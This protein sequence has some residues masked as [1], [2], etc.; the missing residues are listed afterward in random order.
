MK[1]KIFLKRLFEK[2]TTCIFVALVLV[3][4]LAGLLA[5][6]LAPYNPLEQVLD[7][8]LQMASSAHLMGTDHLGRDMFS[9]VLYAI[10]TTLGFAALCTCLAAMIGISLGILAGYI[11]GVLD[12]V[13]MRFCD[14]LYAFPGL[15]LVMAIVGFI[16]VGIFNVVIGMLLTQWLWYARVSR[17]LTVAEKTRSYIS[18]AKV[19]G[20]SGLKIM[21]GHI[22]PNI[23]P[24]ML[25]IFTVDFG[26]TI[27]SISGYSFLGLGVQPPGAELGAMINEGRNYINSDP[28]LIFWPGIVVLIVVVSVN[29][30][31]D[32]MRDALDGTK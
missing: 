29:I 18:A 22:L 25:A 10:R 17:N 9:R 5:G 15:V 21:T 13:I 32:N 20:A 8:K 19:N 7:D 24:N 28:W 23:I 3:I 11:G 4:V 14:I 31:G 27:L 1:M 16:G 30:I 6:V 12:M 26:H 2:K